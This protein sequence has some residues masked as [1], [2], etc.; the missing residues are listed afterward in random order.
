MSD[1]NIN[2]QS[3]DQLISF[4]KKE[5]RS[6]IVTQRD[7][8]LEK[9]N[10]LDSRTRLAIGSFFESDTVNTAHICEVSQI[11]NPP[12]YS[13]LE[14][15]G[16][17]IPLD[18]RDMAGITFIDTILIA[19]SKFDEKNRISLVFHECVHVAQYRYLGLESFVHEYVAGWA[20]NSFDYYKIPL[21][22]Q[23]Y[24]LQHLFESVPHN[25]FSV[26]REVV[27]KWGV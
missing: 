4:L 7:V 27:Q 1:A 6:W 20:G 19:P 5:G 11:E 13:D 17:S 21:E 26:E 25:V 14:E 8:H 15:Q 16:V 3:F 23:A 2:G 9:S 18:F 22:V 24:Q 12:F 10:E